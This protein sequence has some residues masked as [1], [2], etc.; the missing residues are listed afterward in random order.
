[1][2]DIA[3][4]TQKVLA[5]SGYGI[6]RELVGHGVGH[7]LHEDPDIPNYG[8]KGTGMRLKAGMTIAVEPMATLGERHIVLDSNHWTV[9]TV[10]GS[11]AAHAEHTLLITEDGCEVLTSD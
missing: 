6:V 10:D 7:Q 2:G 9:R 5:V 3:A 8:I 4:A 11:L 1:V